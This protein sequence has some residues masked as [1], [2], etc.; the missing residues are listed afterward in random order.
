MSNS[1]TVTYQ[2]ETLDS[3]LYRATGTTDGIEQLMMSAANL[4]TQVCLPV[5]T[6][7]ILPDD[8]PVPATAAVIQLWD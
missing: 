1:E 5:G 4:V 3:L 6:V 2:D 8:E 7:V